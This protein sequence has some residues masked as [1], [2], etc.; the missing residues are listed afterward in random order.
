MKRVSI[1]C[2]VLVAAFATACQPAAEKQIRALQ[3]AAR[4]TAVSKPE[5]DAAEP[6]IAA[7]PDG[8][9]FV[10]FAEHLPDKSGNV[11]LQ[12]FDP[13]LKAVGEPLRI[14]PNAGEARTWAGDPPT[15]K[16]GADGTVYVGWTRR[17]GDEKRSGTDL[18]LSVSRDGGAT[19]AEPV[20]VNDDSIPASHGMHSLAVAPDGKVFM[21]WLD[22]RNIRAAHAAESHHPDQNQ[23]GVYL[24]K[25]HHTPEKKTSPAANT[26]ETAEPPEPNSE[27]YF[28]AS[29]DGGRT[30]SRNMRVATDVCPCCKTSMAV[31]PDGGLYLSWRQ[32]LPGSFRHIAVARSGDNGKTFSPAAIVSDDQWQINA[33]PVSGASLAADGQKL[34]VAWYSAGAAGPPGLYFTESTDG[35]KTFAL[36]RLAGAGAVSGLPWLVGKPG[37]GLSLVYA[38]E[39]KVVTGR[40]APDG[41]ISGTH[42]V[43]SAAVPAACAAGERVVVAFVRTEDGH[44]SVIVAEAGQGPDA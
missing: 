14:N 30:F 31:S 7:A 3:P 19:F 6:A 12:R 40:I 1:F 41:A 23:Q 24:I 26:T 43:A 10:V 37:P 8:A 11:Y 29:E 28:A 36:R 13:S 18:M 44:R 17:T 16:A 4:E 32:V 34:A 20:K 21:A 33:C 5:Q 35:G 15:V 9:V 22:E 38:G 42:S 39:N 2:L 25:A 27:V